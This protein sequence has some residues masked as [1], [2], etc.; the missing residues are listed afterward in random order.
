MDD[1]IEN[2]Q[3]DKSTEGNTIP[4]YFLIVDLRCVKMHQKITD[5]R[6]DK[7]K[8]RNKPM[9]D[10]D[11]SKLLLKINKKYPQDIEEHFGVRNII[12]Q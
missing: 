10:V 2:D 7:S 1:I 11:V 12:D 3:I 4:I 6:K 8:I 5:L 9:S